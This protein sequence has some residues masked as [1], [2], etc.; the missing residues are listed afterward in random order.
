M[1]GKNFY[2][3]GNIDKH[4][5]IDLLIN[6]YLSLP[7]IKHQLLTKNPEKKK[8]TVQQRMEDTTFHG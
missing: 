7:L 2:S 6:E 3:A 8:R 4:K 1:Q 5:Y